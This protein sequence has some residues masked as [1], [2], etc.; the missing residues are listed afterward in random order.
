MRDKVSKPKKGRFFP[1]SYN[2]IL[3]LLEKQNFAVS[4]YYS[5]LHLHLENCEYECENG[6]QLACFNRMCYLAVFSLPELSNE[7]TAKLALEYAISEFG[8]ID[9]L[10]HPVVRGQQIVVYRAYLKS[11]AIVTVTQHI[12]KAGISCNN[13]FQMSKSQKQNLN[14]SVISNTNFV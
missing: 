12:F 8:R 1:L 2:E 6:L 9:K 10:P 11:P 13:L 5:R 14:E 4:S 7:K 3:H